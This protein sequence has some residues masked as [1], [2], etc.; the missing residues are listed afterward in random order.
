MQTIA[1]GVFKAKCL[2]IMDEV[3]A[4]RESIVITKNGKPVAK[5]VPVEK[6]SPD[7]IFGSMKDKATIVGDI[8][9]PIPEEEW[10][11]FK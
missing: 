11:I 2:A 10:E 8:E 1:A 4:K 9:S 3:Q 6:E 7:P 5:L